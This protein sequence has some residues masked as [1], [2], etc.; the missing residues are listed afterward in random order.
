MFSNFF[1]GVPL[2]KNFN[3]FNAPPIIFWSLNKKSEIGKASPKV[4][5]SSITL[6]A[7]PC[8]SKY[9]WLDYTLITNLMH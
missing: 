8:V 4:G 1:T 9:T 2:D 6:P 5:L 7:M 3:N